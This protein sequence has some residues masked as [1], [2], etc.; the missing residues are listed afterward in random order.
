MRLVF[1]HVKKVNHFLQSILEERDATLRLVQ[2]GSVV[3]VRFLH[4]KSTRPFIVVKVTF[5]RILIV[6]ARV[7]EQ[8]VPKLKYAMHDV[9]SKA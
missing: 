6:V 9:G 4:A 8:G 2:V 3:L 5:H 1:P 7:T